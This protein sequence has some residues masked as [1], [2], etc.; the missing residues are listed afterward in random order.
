M[1]TEVE[2]ALLDPHDI[3]ELWPAMPAPE[4][5]VPDF[6]EFASIPIVVL[7]RTDLALDPVQDAALTEEQ[8]TAQPRTPE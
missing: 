4:E 1:Q 5:Q 7:P 6:P 8:L 2:Q 3:A